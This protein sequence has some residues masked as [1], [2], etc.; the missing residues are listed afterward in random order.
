MAFVLELA[1]VGVSLIE[2]D[3]WIEGIL[4]GLY[5]VSHKKIGENSCSR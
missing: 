1:A 3:M 5:A 4:A 2:A